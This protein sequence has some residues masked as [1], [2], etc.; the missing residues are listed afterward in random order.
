MIGDSAGA[1]LAV[2]VSLLAAARGYRVPDN[3]IS[4]YGVFSSDITTFSPSILLSIDEEL[5]SQHAINLF[6]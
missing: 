6:V 4:L 5:L 2:S 1:N 3:I